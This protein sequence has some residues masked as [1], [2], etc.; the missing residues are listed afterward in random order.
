MPSHIVYSE[1]GEVEFNWNIEEVGGGYEYESVQVAGELCITNVKYAM[2]LE[3]Y[4]ADEIHEMENVTRYSTKKKDKAA[5]SKYK[6]VKDACLNI[7]LE[8]V[9]DLD[10]P[11]QENEMGGGME[12]N[13]Q[14]SG[15]TGPQE[16]PMKVVFQ[17]WGM[18]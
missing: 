16:E 10:N 3:H 5:Y 17:E 2:M 14:Q 7:I 13:M 1:N 9:G 6:S 18:Q 11:V 15:P 12:E 8:A 4:T